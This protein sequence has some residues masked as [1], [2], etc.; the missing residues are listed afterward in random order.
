[1][2]IFA[3]LHAVGSAFAA[4]HYKRKYGLAVLKFVLLNVLPTFALAV[5]LYTVAYLI[6]SWD[7]L[8]FAVIGVSMGGYTIG[9]AVLLSLIVGI[10]NALDRKRSAG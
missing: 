9:Y 7:G 5:L 6:G 3:V 2:S 8:I 10:A 1:M 4:L